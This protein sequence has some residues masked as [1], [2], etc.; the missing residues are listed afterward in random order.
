MSRDTLFSPTDVQGMR[1]D[2]KMAARR[3]EGGGIDIGKWCEELHEWFRSGMDLVLQNGNIEEREAFVGC[4]SALS[5][6]SMIADSQMSAVFSSQ[7]VGCTL[8]V[9][10]VEVGHLLASSALCR[11][12][13]V[14][15]SLSVSS[16]CV[17][18]ASSAC[19][20]CTNLAVVTWCGGTA[21]SLADLSPSPSGSEL[22]P[23]T[24]SLSQMQ[25]EV[26]RTVREAALKVGEADLLSM[27]GRI[28]GVA[29]M[30]NGAGDDE[31]A[32]RCTFWRKEEENSQETLLLL[33]PDLWV[34][35]LF[36]DYERADRESVNGY[37]TFSADACLLLKHSKRVG[38][39][40][41]AWQIG[42]LECEQVMG[43]HEEMRS[44]VN[45]K[46]GKRGVLCETTE[47]HVLLVRELSSSN[48]LAGVCVRW[49]KVKAGQG[50][51]KEGHLLW[52][53]TSANSEL[54]TI[55]GGP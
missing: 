55:V 23:N 51:G 16:E 15:A 36:K 38:E 39:G 18:V 31:S 40:L 29:H 49:G 25:R 8:Q 41:R 54:E 32:L 35:F 53:L 10:S 1:I 7:P 22:G 43:E 13:L 33:L 21:G 3:D 52:V 45:E 46:G 9:P 30:E 44:V 34:Q 2:W 48:A 12:F 5:S 17:R 4:L 26:E 42:K 14:S 37:P 20:P 47:G 6:T 24:P 11:S 28:G 19:L 27:R 50:E